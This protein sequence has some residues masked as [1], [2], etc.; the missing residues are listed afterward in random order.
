MGMDRTELLNQIITF[1]QTREEA[2]MQLA[3]L[4]F[5]PH[6]EPFQLS[7]TILSDVLTKYITNTITTDELEEWANFIECRHDIS[8]SNVEG[9]IYALANPEQMGEISNDKIHQML[10]LLTQA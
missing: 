5:D 8:F 1:G 7:K 10:T 9:Y 4:A 3:K 2:F 6:A